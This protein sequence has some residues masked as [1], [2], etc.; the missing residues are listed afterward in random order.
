MALHK[1]K[2]QNSIRKGDWG[3]N[4]IRENRAET[5]LLK[6]RKDL[7]K[8]KNLLQETYCITYLKR[9]KYET[10]KL[11]LEYFGGVEKADL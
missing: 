8:K 10:E 7:C 6:E 1:K 11:E 2:L 5:V 9:E 3:S 4:H